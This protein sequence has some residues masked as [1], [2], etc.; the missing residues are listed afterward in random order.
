MARADDEYG[1][2]LFDLDA[3]T[4]EEI[5]EH[6]WVTGLW[7]ESNDPWRQAARGWY[8][9]FRSFDVNENHQ[10]AWEW[11]CHDV[12]EER[13][14]HEKPT[15]IFVDVIR[16]AILES[17]PAEG[18]HLRT[19]TGSRGRG[20]P[21]N[22]WLTA[23]DAAAFD[24]D[25]A[26]FMKELRR[27]KAARRKRARHPD[28]SPAL[29]HTPAAASAEIP[30]PYSKRS[31][32]AIPDPSATDAPAETSPSLLAAVPPQTPPST[33]PA[34]APADLALVYDIFDELFAE[35]VLDIDALAA[36]ATAAATA[37]P[38]SPPPEENLT[39]A[40]SVN[41]TDLD[42][43]EMLLLLQSLD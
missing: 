25:P 4:E 11:F 26:T 9:P 30:W 35:E 37:A 5:A 18:R 41:I 6:P 22:I 20:K 43:S 27:L 19:Y 38:T 36:P 14:G 33:A 42:E 3:T 21:V 7:S 39:P 40:D 15:G 23:E 24:A 16:E 31:R 29:V 32:V 1:I 8:Y 2:G 10:R 12:S 28:G 34:D 17:L 13:R